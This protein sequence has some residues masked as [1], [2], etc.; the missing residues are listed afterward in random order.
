LTSTRFLKLARDRVKENYSLK[1]LNE[2]KK[3]LIDDG[4]FSYSV[5]V[6]HIYKCLLADLLNIGT[7]TILHATLKA[8]ARK[9]VTKAKNKK[10]TIQD[11]R[12]SF[13]FH[14]ASSAEM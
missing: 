2:L 14:L 13:Y 8:K 7:R 9:V 12:Q 5:K 11:A 10:L 3:D 6:Y 4:K 1:V